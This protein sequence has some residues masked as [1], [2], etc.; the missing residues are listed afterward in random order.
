MQTEQLSPRDTTQLGWKRSRG[1]CPFVIEQILGQGVPKALNHVII[2]SELDN[3]SNKRFTF[4]SDLHATPLSSQPNKSGICPIW[5]YGCHTS[6]TVQTL[7]NVTYS[8]RMRYS[9][10]ICDWSNSCYSR[11][12]L[13]IKKLIVAS[14]GRGRRFTPRRV[15]PTDAR[16]ARQRSCRSIRQ[17][18]TGFHCYIS[19]ASVISIVHAQVPAGHTLCPLRR[20]K[21]ALATDPAALVES[22]VEPGPG[23]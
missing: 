5:V 18:R 8:D 17:P 4:I 20:S 7:S 15:A 2:L 16:N 21:G 10:T 11:K 9:V 14:G 22:S 1:S 13:I 3:L 12:L 6:V 19:M 23:S